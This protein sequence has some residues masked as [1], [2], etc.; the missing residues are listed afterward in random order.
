MLFTHKAARRAGG[1]EGGIIAVTRPPQ[2]QE[3]AETGTG[4]SPPLSLP[5]G[6]EIMHVVARPARVG[7]RDFL[8]PCR[9][10]VG[11]RG[12]R[13][14]VTFPTGTSKTVV[15]YALRGQAAVPYTAVATGVTGVPLTV[16]AV[17]D[18]TPRSVPLDLAAALERAGLDWIGR[19]CPPTNRLRFSN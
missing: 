10:P 12:T 11:Q 18:R 5:V 9:G 1:S 2:P 16:Q 6:A 7:G 4:P 14:R 8:L 19:R 3:P 17:R 13:L 15:T